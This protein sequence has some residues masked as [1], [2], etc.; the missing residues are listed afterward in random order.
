[1]SDDLTPAEVTPSQETQ[2]DAP[3]AAPHAPAYEPPPAAPAG[4][5]RVRRGAGAIWWGLVLIVIGGF[6][7]LRQF[8]PD[9]EIL[10]RFWPLSIGG[11][12]VIA[13][14]VRAMFGSSTG[15]WTMKVAAEGLVLV[16][17]GLVLLGQGLGYLGWD[18]WVN[19]LKL[20]PLIL[21]SIGLDVIGRGTRAEWLR[22]VS[23]LVII[24]GIAYG[25]LFMTSNA[26]WPPLFIA[27]T[28]ETEPFS[29]RA[30]H[31]SDVTEGSATIKAA[32]SE[33]TLE[34]GSVLASAEGRSQLEL[35][36]EATTSN[37]VADV[38]IEL[39]GSSLG[40][41]GD[42]ELDVTLD[43][44]VPW[45]LKIDTG[46]SSFDVDL[47]DLMV[48]S[49]AFNAGVSEGTLTLGAS[50]ADGGSDGVEAT[51]KG[52]V[53]S[54]TIRVPEGDD[55]RVAVRAGISTLDFR[56][57]W[58]RSDDGDRRVYESPGFS[59]SDTYWDIELD[60]GIGTI[61]VEYY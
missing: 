33:F 46:V 38:T 29:E 19:I 8:A 18:V 25:A 17:I 30:A 10:G 28:I 22:V 35:D 53:S 57:E 23:S 11:I 59:T 39:K 27:G 1:M 31:E 44:Q 49:L 43:E 34:G 26:G 4:S 2:P 3:P 37:E 58:D 6:L 15:H 5:E 40:P 47:S 55:V 14:G 50:D 41:I 60:A 52:G 16:A 61:D 21:V 48:S 36:F 13:L 32:A 45:D 54:L 56:G 42:S 24:A 12:I 7:L 20:W 51:I 9:V